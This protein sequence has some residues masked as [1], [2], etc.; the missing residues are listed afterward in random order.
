MR[1]L[2]QPEGTDPSLAVGASGAAGV[3]ALLALRADPALDGLASALGMTGR[4]RAFVIATEGVTEPDLWND[5]V[6]PLP[7]SVTEPESTRGD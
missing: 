3:A 5:T 4:T 6:G 7:G 2:A 1:R